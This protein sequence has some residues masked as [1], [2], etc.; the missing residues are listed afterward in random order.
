MTH[1]KKNHLGSVLVLLVFAVFVVSILLVLLTGADV[2]QKLN[3]RD[4]RSY[5][6]RTVYQYLTTRIRQADQKGMISVRETDEGSVLVLSEIIE[7]EPY[8]TLVYC[9]E[10]YLNE[11][12]I[13]AGLEMELEFGESILPLR[14]LQCTDF[15]DRIHISFTMTDGQEQQMMIALRSEREGSL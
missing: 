1:M 4:Q 13:E 10:G 8:E 7:D 15:G 5:D 2:V 11:L 9:R 6:H 14:Q 3:D 12:F